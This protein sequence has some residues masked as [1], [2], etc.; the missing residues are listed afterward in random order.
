[1]LHRFAMLFDNLLIL[2]PFFLAPLYGSHSY[3]RYES[4]EQLVILMLLSLSAWGLCLATEQANSKDNKKI[5]SWLKVV[6]L[7]LLLILNCALIDV[8]RLRFNHIGFNTSDPAST[9]FYLIISS[10]LALAL[11]HFAKSGIVIFFSSVIWSAIIANLSFYIMSLK[12]SWQAFLIAFGFSILLN[13]PLLFELIRSKKINLPQPTRWIV[14]LA[15]LGPLLACSLCFIDQLPRAYT[16]A[17]LPLLLLI[18]LPNRIEAALNGKF[19]PRQ[20][21]LELNSL[22]ILFLIACLAAGYFDPNL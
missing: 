4:L 3:L 9:A 2:L 6:R 14:S 18:K 16:L 20:V 12:W 5:L 17:L 13:I 7:I 10:I 22:I 11:K 19:E 1:M 8:A 21:K 15:G